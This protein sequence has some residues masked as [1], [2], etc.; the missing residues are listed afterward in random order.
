[1]VKQQN[2]SAPQTRFASYA[3]VIKQMIIDKHGIVSYYITNK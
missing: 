3:Y 2:S 1:M